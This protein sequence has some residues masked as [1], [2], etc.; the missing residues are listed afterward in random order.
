[1][2]M[3]GCTPHDYITK[4][5]FWAMEYPACR[6][7]LSHIKHLWDELKRRIRAKLGVPTSVP[8]LIVLG[9]AE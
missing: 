2:T 1:M 9:E 3:R 5:G 6:F 7:E 8:E 4:V